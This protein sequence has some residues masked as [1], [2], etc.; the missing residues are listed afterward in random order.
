MRCIPMFHPRHHSDRPSQYDVS[1]V[2]TWAAAIV[3]CSVVWAALAIVV[4]GL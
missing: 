4:A 3:F 1:L 2:V